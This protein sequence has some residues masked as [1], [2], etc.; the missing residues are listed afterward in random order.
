M[1]IVT[2]GTIVRAK[3]E[4]RKR[5]GNETRTKTVSENRK[6]STIEHTTDNFR[7]FNLKLNKIFSQYRHQ[8]HVT[9]SLVTWYSTLHANWF[10]LVRFSKPS[11]HTAL[12]FFPTKPLF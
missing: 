12:A 11:E 1:D 7:V 6:T 8:Y 9:Y 2:V 3:T 5:D 10:I 4:L